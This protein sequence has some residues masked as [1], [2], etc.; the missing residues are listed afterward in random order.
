MASPTSLNPKSVAM[1]EKWAKTF[2]TRPLSSTECRAIAE[3]YAREV[4]LPKTQV[5]RRL[6]GTQA[7]ILVRLG[8][9]IQVVD[10]G[11]LWALRVPGEHPRSSQLLTEEALWEAYQAHRHA[12]QGNPAGNGT[13]NLSWLLTSFC[14]MARAMATSWARNDI[15][16]AFSNALHGAGRGGSRFD[17]FDDPDFPEKMRMV[18]GYS[19]RT[20]FYQ[21]CIG[22]SLR[23]LRE[24]MPREV[25]KTLWAIHCPDGRLAHWIG[26]APNAIALQRR[27]QALRE[28]PL[29]LPM[30][31]HQ[32]IQTERE[33]TRHLWQL[34]EHQVDQGDAM[35][36]TLLLLA[37]QEREAIADSVVVN[38]FLGADPHTAKNWTREDLAFLAHRPIH[39]SLSYTQASSH[40]TGV[41]SLVCFVRHLDPKRHPKRPSDWRTVQSIVERMANQC[42]RE[43]F[44]HTQA[45]AF[46]E[47][48][49][50]DWQD[51]FYKHIYTKMNRVSRAIGWLNKGE[52]SN[53][54]ASRR[55]GVLLEKLTLCQW[56]DLADFLF[57]D[58]FAWDTA[59]V[60][61]EDEPGSPTG[62]YRFH[63]TGDVGDALMRVQGHARCLMR[64]PA[65]VSSFELRWDPDQ[66]RVFVKQF[67]ASKNPSQEKAGQLAVDLLQG[68][69]L[70]WPRTPGANRWLN[71]EEI[72]DNRTAQEWLTK[73]MWDAITPWVQSARIGTPLG[74]TAE[75][76]AAP[77]AAPPQLF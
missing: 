20:T 65:L 10:R 57:L 43:D 55:M 33:G 23:P 34:L 26:Q 74:G 4:D 9:E 28:Q 76:P 12:A 25:C 11:Q 35:D 72:Q 15:R 16:N 19:A 27:C 66:K 49:P 42:G 67:F 50:T 1:G 31:F 13:Q 2:S 58:L 22:A 37:R 39:R 30:A 68:S 8:I 60:F 70:S 71:P 56:L 6:E 51:P 75:G 69:H 77:M 47:G 41:P 24:A 17:Y 46:M 45:A 61:G 36:H 59:P 62:S 52:S 54:A 29:L 44:F 64:G 63:C 18:R 38:Q 5:F 7:V 21:S 73:R 14:G 48:S 32:G 53:R 40:L 3:A